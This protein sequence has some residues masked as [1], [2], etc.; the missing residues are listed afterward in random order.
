VLGSGPVRRGAER[1]VLEAVLQDG[2][3]GEVTRRAERECAHA[4][5]LE[6]RRAVPLGQAQQPEA[7]AVALLGVRAGLEDAADDRGASRADR[8]APADQATRRPLEV[9]AVCGRQ[10]LGERGVAAAL[11]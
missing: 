11:R 9:L 6:S 5:R 2:L 4:R 10:V 3:H 8:L 7:S 1:G